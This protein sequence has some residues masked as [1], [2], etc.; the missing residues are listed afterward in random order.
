MGGEAFGWAG[1]EGK[2]VTA[3]RN[4]SIRPAVGTARRFTRGRGWLFR[5][6]GL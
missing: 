6:H 4:R 1:G 5:G 3:L 2:S